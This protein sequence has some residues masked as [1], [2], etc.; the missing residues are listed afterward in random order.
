MTLSMGIAAVVC[1]FLNLYP[2]LYFSV[3]GQG[4]RF[5]EEGTPTLRIVA[6]ALVFS[7]AAVV[8]LNSVTGTGQSR[9]TFFIEL[10]AIVL[11]CIYVYVVLEVKRLPISWGWASELLYWTV[12][13]LASFFYIRRGKW[14]EA[15][16]L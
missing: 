3:F 8:W 11:Y 9:I 2:A 1:L 13:F 15:K 6:L 5:V 14:K 4:E 7:A 10:A 12:I 16:R